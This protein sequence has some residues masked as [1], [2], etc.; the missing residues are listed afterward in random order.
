MNGKSYGRIGKSNETHQQR[1]RLMWNNV[2]YQP[3]ELKVVAYNEQG[4]AVDEKIVRTSGK[5]HHLEVHA[6][7]SEIASDGKDLAYITVRA[8]DKDGNLCPFDGRLVRFEM[9]GAGVYRAS[10][11]GDPTCVDLFHLPK[12]H[13]FS[14]Q[15]T[16]IVQA[17]VQPGQIEF[18]ANADGLKSGSVC[19]SVV[20]KLK[21]RFIICT[22]RYPFVIG[23]S[24][25]IIFL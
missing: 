4:I 22:M 2:I 21:Y 7:H 13:L 11:N 8:V 15:L 23:R 20:S 3:G 6:N 5:A 25:G 9:K 24:E 14:G 19:I 18:K 17:G 16:A 10:A 1:Y 12:M